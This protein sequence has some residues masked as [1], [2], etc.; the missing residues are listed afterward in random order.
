MKK[1][2]GAG[3]QPM[4]APVWIICSYDEAGKANGMTASWAGICNSSPPCIYASIRKSRYT[5]DNIMA[6]KAFTACVPAAS[7]AKEADYLGIA[8]GRDEDKFARAGLTAVA[9][10]LVDA[11]TIEEFPVAIECTVH[12]TL[13]LGSHTVFIG[14]VK[15]V[16]VEE[17]GLTDGQPDAEKLDIFVWMDG[18]RGLGRPLGKAFSIG[19][20][21]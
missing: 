15:D 5:Y 1:S 20:D 6:R 14:E 8:S 13:D 16:K 18:Y 17:A 12:Q 10:E 21:I 2:L 7:H 11:P 4:P 3:T 9:S 19:K